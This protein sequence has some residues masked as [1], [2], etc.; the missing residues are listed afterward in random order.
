MQTSAV[1]RISQSSVSPIEQFLRDYVA[2]REGAW[3]EVEPQVYDVLIESDLMQVAFDPEA[4]PEHP[5]AQ[6]AAFG[7]PLVDRLLADARSRWNSAVC[8]RTGVHL[9]PFNLEARVSRAIALPDGAAIRLERKRAMHFPLAVF[10][11]RATFTSDQK[12]EVVLPVGIDL[13]ELREVRQLES[14]LAF[15]RLSPEPQTPLPEAPHRGAIPG[16]RTALAHAVR[17]I[18]PLANARRRDWAGAV[19]KQIGRMRGYYARL[20]D[21]TAVPR[22]RIADPAVAE[23]RLRDRRQSI[24]REEQ[25]RIAELQRKAD[26]RVEVKLIGWLTV[27]QPKLLLAASV[28]SKSATCLPIQLV[29]DPQ[30]DFVDAATCPACLQPT[31]RLQIGREGLHCTGCARGS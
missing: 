11:F 7:S 3:D 14:V 18:T 20:R 17:S 5:E 26:L 27:Y 16:Y 21:E 1:N 10:W 12:E 23:A 4:L 25:L 6:L 24:D 8:Y 19:Q 9:D 30:S 13:H 31:F 15:D 28:V 22:G 2:A 29:W